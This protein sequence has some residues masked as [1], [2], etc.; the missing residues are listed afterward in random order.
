MSVVRSPSVDFWSVAN[1]GWMSF[2]S[3]IAIPTISRIVKK[4]IPRTRDIED[5]SS[6][7]NELQNEE[8]LRQDVMNLV[9][10][11]SRLTL[12][13]HSVRLCNQMPSGHSVS[14]G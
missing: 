9:K 13:S 4:K 5:S 12:F 7:S 14:K 6:P 1:A 10:K 8:Q 3:T 2:V 11:L